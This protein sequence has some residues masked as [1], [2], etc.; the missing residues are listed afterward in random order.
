MKKLLG[1]VVLGLLWGNTTLSEVIKFEC[2]N[3]KFQIQEMILD[4]NLKKIT[5]VTKY[6][7]EFYNDVVK[8]RPGN[9]P[10]KSSAIFEVSYLGD[11]K[12]KYLAG[13]YEFD[14]NYNTD[15][16]VFIK[17]LYG[18]SKLLFTCIKVGFVN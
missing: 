16:K 10:Q 3:P 13:N 6:K 5:T 4:K 15:G 1:I 7:D 9:T 14:F 11:N 2:N 8:K 12:L 17:N 18:N